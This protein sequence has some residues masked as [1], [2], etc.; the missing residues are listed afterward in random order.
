MRRLFTLFLFYSLLTTGFA[1]I[2]APDFLCV[3]NAVL[4]WQ[5]AAGSPCGP[6]VAYRIYAATAN[7]GPYTLLATVTDPLV[8]TY[9]HI[10]SNSQL[11]YYYLETERDCPG[12]INLTSDTLNNRIPSTGPLCTA[13][14][15]NGNEVFLTWQPSISPQVIGYVVSRNT[16]TGLVTID[17]VYNDTSYLDTTVNADVQPATYYVVAIDACGN[18]SLVE[19]P[20]T[21]MVLE[22][23]APASACNPAVLLQWTP[24]IGFDSA[25]D[26]YQVLVNGV[27]LQQSGLV[28]AD[29]LSY[30]F[31]YREHSELADFSGGELCFTIAAV[32][33]GSPAKQALSSVSCQVIT[34]P[35]TLTYIDLLTASFAADNRL[36][37]D[38]NWNENIDIATAYIERSSSTIGPDVLPL[39]VSNPP[40]SS[41][42]YT[43]AQ[44]TGQ[45]G[46]LPTDL[47]YQV[48]S[49][50]EC[51]DETRSNTV[52]PILLTGNLIDNSRNELR[53]TPFRSELLLRADQELIRRNIDGNETTLGLFS[54]EVDRFTDLLDGSAAAQSENCYYIRAELSLQ[55]TDGRM[56]SRSVRSNTVC[57]QP[58]AA[59]YIPNV[60]APAGSNNTVFRPFVTSAQPETFSMTIYDR[61]GGQVFHS[62]NI[63]QGWAGTHRGGIATTGTYLYQMRFTFADGTA[64]ERSGDILLLR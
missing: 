62:D 57:F 36:D 64:I 43:D 15:T 7:E 63:S 3:S 26:N 44:F 48:V 19:N 46:A 40:M 56:V 59:I 28:P 20:H 55:L 45:T 17:T 42:S 37:L 58:A 52:F 41:A 8:T 33:S 18:K 35:S 39:T 29:Q 31:D 47:R 13:S 6:F 25:L 50:N 23:T 9:D 14:V 49:T 1:Q 4:Q 24:Y 2:A 10:G 54:N 61:W 16:P 5:P 21:T 32:S 53:W 27:P 34:L 12:Q 60:F 51:G 22:A 30:S 11:W 38:W